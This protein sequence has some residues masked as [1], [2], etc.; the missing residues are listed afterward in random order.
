[1]QPTDPNKFTEIAW[2]AIVRSQEIC[3]EL[4]NQNLE[5]EH[6]ILALLAEDTIAVQIFQ[7]ANVEINRLQ[8]QLQTFATRQPRMYSVDQLYLGRSL[9]Q[10]LDRAE[11]CRVS[12]QDEY[13]GVSHLLVAFADDQRIGKKTLRSFNL[14]PQDFE[15]KVRDFKVKIEKMEAETEEKTEKN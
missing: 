4:K 9:D 2:D 1:M 3:K 15:Q 13:I 14:D 12:W 7:K 6:L 10:M 5:V 11:N 8:K